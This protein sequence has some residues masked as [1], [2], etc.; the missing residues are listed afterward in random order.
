MSELRQH[1]LK[2]DKSLGSKLTI[3]WEEAGLGVHDKIQTRGPSAGGRA[4]SDAVEANVWRLN[5][6]L[7]LSLSPVEL[8]VLSASAALH[9]AA[10]VPDFA[11]EGQDH[12]RLSERLIRLHPDIFKLDRHQAA[13]IGAVVGPHNDGRLDTLHAKNW[14]LGHY[15]Q[16]EVVKLAALFR[17]CDMLDIAER[18]SH[19]IPI[20]ICEKAK[21]IFRD[22][23]SG[24]KLSDDKSSIC[25]CA[26][27]DTPEE[28]NVILEGVERTRKDVEPIVVALQH[29][30]LPHRLANA[31]IDV[32]GIKYAEEDRSRETKAFIGLD[33]FHE[34]DAEA[35]KGRDPEIGELLGRVMANPV[36][37]LIGASGAGKTSLI[38]AG[39]FPK[40]KAGG[41]KCVRTRPW[42]SA[43]E[44]VRRKDFEDL[45]GYP[46]RSDTRLSDLAEALSDKY[47]SS[48]ILISLD[49]FEDA[50]DLLALDTEGDFRRLLRVVLSRK[51]PKVHLLIA[52]RV[53]AE[54][55]FGRLWQEAAGSATGLPRTYLNPLDRP[56]AEEALKDTLRRAKTGLEPA[57]R[58][59]KRLLDDLEI[60]T[61]K[62]GHDKGVY[63]PYLRILAE[64]VISKVQSAEDK[65]FTEK[66]YDELEGA[67]KVIGGYLFNT[68]DRLGEDKEA[69]QRILVA[70]TTSAGTKAPRSLP[71]LVAET[72]I[73]EG[74]LRALLARLTDLRLVR[75]VG[76]EHEIAHDYLADL[77]R[78]RLVERHPR[79]LELKALQEML[80]A[81]TRSYPLTGELLTMTEMCRLYRHR[82][83]VIPSAAELSY[84]FGSM[85]GAN[86]EAPGWYWLRGF[87]RPRA[88]QEAIPMLQNEDY[89][90]REIASEA[91]GK[92]ATYDD[93]PRV[94][95]MLVS[96]F[97]DVR[98]AAAEV[99]GR[100]VTYDE[101]PKINQI[102]QNEDEDEFLRTAAAE[103]FGRLATRD[104]SAMIERMLEDKDVTVRWGAVEALGRLAAYE[105]MSGIERMLEDKE[106]AVRQAAAG[107]FGKLATHK[108]L[109]KVKRM[110]EN[111]ERDVCYAAAKAF[112]NL[113]TRDQL[114]EIEQMLRAKEP[115]TRLAAVLAFQRLATYNDLPTIERMFR[116][117]ESAVRQAA[118]EAFGKLAT[119]DELPIIHDMLRNDEY[120]VRRAAAEAFGRIADRNDFATIMYM[121]RRDNP[122]MRQAAEEAF[123]KL[124]TREDL[125]RIEQMLR[126]DD[127]YVHKVAGKVFIRISNRDDLDR[128]EH[129]IRDKDHEMHRAA[130]EAYVR[131]AEQ[132]DLERL[133]DSWVSWDEVGLILDRAVYL[134]ESLRPL[135][136]EEE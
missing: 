9:D 72:E 28:C 21:N 13:I 82:R 126:G 12:G 43:N 66:M 98:Q 14:V 47:S 80:A 60:E 3:I 84:L 119:H 132:Q 33:Y 8:F 18:I 116:D 48:E 68:L 121:L 10:R 74:N 41:W 1:V 20:P 90:L 23:V 32:A 110:L 93:L 5:H 131:L 57:D 115:A 49:Q 44:V 38:L 56:G 67:E 86:W 53:E 106:P 108:D 113:A 6:E 37:L 70:L 15:G 30:G 100:L 39:L 4:H 89:D 25:I 133:L 134:P 101:F 77:I 75:P 99:F 114:P 73:Q 7:G 111:E 61:R 40:M 92:L 11:E 58:L 36:S 26:V 29:Y 16:I 96:E 27:A 85:L 34:N 64:T 117:G 109:P 2:K 78:V 45:L 88:C 124:S 71:A 54:V 118:A 55:A 136:K 17:F 50:T 46:S 19:Q 103:A 127:P 102:L 87:S 95:R 94:E 83:R 31:E 76:V 122:I 63:P 112:G 107:A 135:F 129:L 22:C 91:F 125:P 128:I 105:D 81:K 52:Y 130:A 104:D 51:L 35:F 69:G 42:L 123:S 59:T 62:A 97:V 79:E 65:I 24:W 120:D